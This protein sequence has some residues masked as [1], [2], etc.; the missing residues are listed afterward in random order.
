MSGLFSQAFITVLLFGAVTAAVPLLL[1]GLGEQMSEKAGVLN[2]GIEGMMI[3][4]AYAGFVGA[5]YAESLWLGFL[6]GGLAG[7]AVGALM[8]LLCVRFGLNQIVIGIA[9]TLGLQGLTA[10]LHHIQFSRSYP[11]LPAAGNTCDPGAVGSAGGRAG[12]L[13][14]APA[15][16]SRLRAGGVMVYIYRRTQLGLNLQAAGDKPA[17]LDVAGIDVVRTR[18]VAVL[19]TGALAGVGGAYLANVGPACSFPSSPTAP[20]SSASCW[21]C[22]RA[23]GRLGAGWGAAVRGIAVADDSPA[24]RRDQHSDRRHP[25]AAV[26]G[27]D[28]HARDFRPARGAARGV[29]AALHPGGTLTGATQTSELNMSDTKVY[30]L[31]GGSLALDGFHVFWNQGPGGEV[32]IPAYSILIEHAEGRFLIDT[33]YDYDHVMKALAFEKPQQTKDQTMPGALKLLGLEPKDIDVIFNTHFH[34][35]HCGGNKYLPGCQEDLP[36]ARGAAGLQA[37]SVRA[38]GLFRPELFGRSGRGARHDRPAA[39]GHDSRKHHLRRRRGRLRAG[40]GR[41][42]DLHPRPHHRHYS[43]LVELANSKPMMLVLDAAYTKRSLDTLCQAR[44]T[45]TPL[46]AFAPCCGSGRWRR[47][48]M[49]TCSSPTT[50]SSS[51]P[52]RPAP[53]S[54]AD[55]GTGGRHAPSR[56]YRTC[57]DAHFGTGE[58]LSRGAPGP[59][60]HRVLRLRS[61]YFQKFYERVVEKARTAMRT[62]TRPVVQQGEPVLGLESAAASLIGKDD[63]VLNLASGVY[64]KGFGYWAKRYTPD[65][66]EIEVPYNE[67]IDPRRSPTCCAGTPRSAWSRVVPPRH[68]VGHASTRSTRSAAGGRSRRLSDRRCGILLRRHEDEPGGLPRRHLCHR[69]EQVPGRAA[70][71]DHARR[72]RAGWDKMKANPDAPRASML[73]SSTGKTPGRTTS[74]FPS[75]HR[76]PR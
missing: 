27:G 75:R 14:P 24:G 2:I 46:R 74:R 42:H 22:W 30:F 38:A 16:L 41:A 76:S 18:T 23:A 68:A 72:Q 33:G 65:L 70:G 40:Q 52:T 15:G 25:D 36:Q 47:S 11:R 8:A 6:V 31:D 35:D 28:G 63:V 21:R 66:L 51:R 4:G 9:L 48:T 53:T 26:R 5:F 19:T 49:R 7:L 64:G 1:A 13:Q 61:G 67:A 71:A 56:R 54:T 20:A 34:F 57:D 17:A 3:T 62:T 55:H 32:R 73:S 10:L 44:S 29:R 50:W 69:S 39:T 43:C 58:R 37:R 59:R 12:V 60:P 45:S